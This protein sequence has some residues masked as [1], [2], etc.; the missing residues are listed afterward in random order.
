MA[1]LACV[2]VLIGWESGARLH[3]LIIR[4]L[5]FSQH[6]GV[7]VLNTNQH[8][9][10]KTCFDCSRTF[11]PTLWKLIKGLFFT[12]FQVKAINIATPWANWNC[13]ERNWNCREQIE[14]AVSKLKLSW[15]NRNCREQIEI[16]VTL[17]GHRTKATKRTFVFLISR[18][19]ISL[20]W[21]KACLIDLS[22][23]SKASDFKRTAT[24]SSP[25]VLFAMRGR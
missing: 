6:F 25:S 23:Y 13:R 20:I 14:T 1:R 3:R 11:I 17:L 18:K 24:L 5:R 21:D 15:T 4:I 16:A 7:H 8:F 22:E 10:G 2:L 12:G 9:T 19:K